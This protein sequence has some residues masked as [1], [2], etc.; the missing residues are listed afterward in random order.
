M[1]FFFRALVVLPL[2]SLLARTAQA[3]LPQ[4]VDDLLAR[5]RATGAR[6]ERVATLFLVGGASRTVLVPIEP[7]PEAGCVTVVA[8]GVRGASFSMGRQGAKLT[9]LAEAADGVLAE[10]TDGPE[11]SD[12]EPEVAVSASRPSRAGVAE[13]EVCRDSTAAEIAANNGH[14]ANESWSSPMAV[15]VAFSSARGTV[16]VVV[17]HHRGPLPA[18]D[19]VLLDRAMGP[20]EPVD[21]RAPALAVAPLAERVN[22]AS[23]IAR[24][25]GADE[26]VSVVTRA[27][28]DGSGALTVKLSAGCHRLAVLADADG[29]NGVDIDAE[30]REPLASTPLRVDR[31]HAPD[32]RLEFCVS[33]SRQ[34]ELRWLGAGAPRP[35]TLLDAHWELPRLPKEW[36][37]GERAAIAGALF[38]RRAPR[39]SEPP[40][41]QWL[42]LVGATQVPL[43]LEP[44]AC[45][46]AALGLGDGDV[47]TARLS[48]DVAGNVFHDDS[49]DLPR[50]AAVTFC[51]QASAKGRAH[52]LLRGRA[53]N[54]R[55][56]LWRLGGDAP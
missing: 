23:K 43:A 18:V 26:V 46:L 1:S 41:G 42:G 29:V 28:E 6:A 52:V 12:D 14:F 54:F 25:D 48:V 17:A 50:G 15:E 34:L 5:W 35:V 8:L 3:D 40:I 20:L 53:A 45:Y 11:L 36:S 39:V 16:D 44:G 4:D 27:A 55:L 32:A 56:A 49:V 31:S 30:L 9:V 22:R 33:E 19:E 2:V 10:A 47:A 24:A 21:D 37:H 38:K 13:L 7:T 51:A